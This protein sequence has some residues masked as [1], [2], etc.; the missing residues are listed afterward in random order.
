MR[1]GPQL[2]CWHRLAVGVVAGTAVHNTCRK[3]IPG[4]STDPESDR[5]RARRHRT[6]RTARSLTINI[7]REVSRANSGFRQIKLHLVADSRS[8]ARAAAIERT[9]SYP[10]AS[11]NVG[12][13][14]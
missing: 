3:P 6:A 2:F 1:P 7:K 4:R 11:R 9:C 10:V 13:R 12:A 5:L 14:P 8:P